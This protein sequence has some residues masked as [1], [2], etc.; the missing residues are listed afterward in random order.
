MLFSHQVKE[1][2]DVCNSGKFPD[3][4]IRRFH[5]RD[6]VIVPEAIMLNLLWVYFY[7]A[8]VQISTKLL[9]KL[10][11]SFTCDEMQ[12]NSSHMLQFLT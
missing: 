10:Y 3:D 5:F 8:I 9:Q 6:H 4:K 12:G 11:K 2:I 1:F 7:K